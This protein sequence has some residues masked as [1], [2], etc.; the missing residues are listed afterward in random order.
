MLAFCI[1]YSLPEAIR[2]AVAE[3]CVN[4]KDK[5]VYGMFLAPF[6]QW[7]LLPWWLRV[8]KE[9]RLV[10]NM[11]CSVE[12]ETCPRLTLGMAP[13][14]LRWLV[15]NVGML[16]EDRIKQRMRDG[17]SLSLELNLATLDP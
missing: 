4:I 17:S 10:D 6:S 11:E 16:S 13:K 2:C 8:V 7:K 1:A 12:G 9:L 15:H 5:V 3:I 14:L